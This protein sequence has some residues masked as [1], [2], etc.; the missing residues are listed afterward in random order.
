MTQVPRPALPPTDA[1]VSPACAPD[2]ERPPAVRTAPAVGRER[3]MPDDREQMTRALSRQLRRMM[4]CSAPRSRSAAED[5]IDAGWMLPPEPESPLAYVVLNT[6]F[7]GLPSKLQSTRI[8]ATREEAEAELDAREERA[9]AD[10]D[11]FKDT[12]YV[13]GEIH[14]LTDITER[15]TE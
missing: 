4:D 7:Q 9:A 2:P 14:P 12:R 15:S 1:Q 11:W 10:P 13:I 8:T 6:H 3:A 5:L